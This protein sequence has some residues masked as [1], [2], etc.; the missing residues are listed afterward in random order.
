[1][2]VEKGQVV[3]VEFKNINIYINEFFCFFAVNIIFVYVLIY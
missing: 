3:L 2:F 1:M